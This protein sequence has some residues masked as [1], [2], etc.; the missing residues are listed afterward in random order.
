MKHYINYDYENTY[1]E[2]AE[3]GRVKRLLEKG[4]IKSVY[5]TKTIKSGKYF[6]VEIYP[7][8]TR[9]EAEAAG[10]KKGSSKAQKNLN[11]KNA[12]KRLKRLINS[13]FT[14]SDYWITFTYDS[15]HMPQ[16][17]EQAQQDM[18]NY[19]RRVNYRRKKK[20][21]ESAKYIYITEQGSKNKRIHHHLIIENGIDADTLEKLWKKGRRNNIRRIAEDENG[22]TG[23]SNYLSKDPQG[24]KRWCSSNNLKK[25]KESKSY[26]VFKFR[27]IRKMIE[28]QNIIQDELERTYKGRRLLN[29]EV[30]YNKYNGR[31]YIYAE[32][33]D[34][35][36]RNQFFNKSRKEKKNV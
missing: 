9:K 20:E 24:R 31:F 27:R 32:M 17:I 1:T 16:T 23:L 2:H 4:E 29:F 11:D 6:E 34:E 10:I 36:N 28:N 33:V 25:P 35:E 3:D 14:N 18:K 30:R 26:S 15:E 12:R 5:A 19:I 22:L 21:L 8:F 7:E 13:N